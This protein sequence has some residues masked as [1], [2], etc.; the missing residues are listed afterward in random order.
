MQKNLKLNKSRAFDKAVGPGK[1]S[2]I[3]KRRLTSIP[4]SRVGTF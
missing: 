3:N 1:K 2:Q 4:E